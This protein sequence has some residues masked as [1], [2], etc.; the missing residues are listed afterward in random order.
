M[1][2]I[3]EFSF[4]KLLLIDGHSLAY[5][6]F[7]A[8]PPLSNAEGIPTQAL[9][10]VVNM[11][12]KILEDEKPTHMMVFFDKEIPAFRKEAYQ[13][14]KA[15]RKAPPDDFLT[16]LPFIEEFY[17]GVLEVPVVAQPGFEADDWIASVVHQAKSEAEQILI[18][19]ADL[20]L[21]QL[22]SENVVVLAS[23]RGTSQF[24]RYTPLEVEK[25]FGVKPFQIPDLKALVGDASDNILGIPGIGEKT[26]A[27]LLQQ[28]GSI[29][30]LFE[31][32]EELPNKFKEKL[33]QF[34][35]QLFLNKAL[36]TLKKDAPIPFQ[37][38]A[39]A[40]KPFHPDKL[41]HFF[42]RFE[43]KKL[44]S[45]LGV[46]AKTNIESP[47]FVYVEH[48]ETLTRLL[49]DFSQTPCAGLLL[50]PSPSPFWEE[51]L[52]AVYLPK[53]ETY[54][55]STD[56]AERALQT[57]FQKKDSKKIFAYN[58]KSF[59]LAGL[60]K[61]IV[62]PNWKVHDVFITGWLCNSNYT[63]SSL[64]DLARLY[65]GVVL[66]EN[67]PQK[68]E[69]A[70]AVLSAWVS[71]LCPLGE[72]LEEKVKSL[73]LISLYEEMEFPLI[74]VLARMEQ[75]GVSLDLAYLQQLSLELREELGRLE[76]EIYKEAG[77]IFNINSSK[78]LADVLYHKLQ[79]PKG[80]KTKTGYSTDVEE[81]ERLSNFSLVPTL[82][83]QYREISKLLNTYVEAFPKLIHP[84]TGR[85]HTTF[86]QTGT[87][88]GRLSSKE[89][90]LQNIP[91]RTEYGKK[92][93]KAFVPGKPG[94]KILSADYSQIELRLLAHFSEDP[95]LIEAFQNHE[96][97]H[98]RTA[99]EIFGVKAD[100]VTPL[101]R[102][103]AKSVNFGILY[104][105]TEHGLSQSLGIKKED[106]REFIK[107]Y[108][109]RFP[110]VQAYLEASLEQ[111]RQAGATRTL[112]GRLRFM[113]ELQSQKGYVR[114]QAERMGVNAP[115]QGSAADL[116]KLA[117]IRVQKRL[118][119]EN[120]QA[121]MIMQV[122]DELVFE[123]PPHEKKEVARLV[124]E[125]MEHTANFRV[126]LVV[127]LAV[128]E[129]WAE[130]VEVGVGS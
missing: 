99:C 46:N 102:R 118:D 85:L 76:G 33:K 22:V 109:E 114:Q 60:Q 88:T 61:N 95:V 47:P 66:P 65:M 73:S 8:L 80:R 69:E 77:L 82:L 17:A 106:A 36:I 124:K 115:L 81:L 4:M 34:K 112:W 19:S 59:V 123:V 87:V 75:N 30:N 125:E 48:D 62:L 116:I 3:A 6:A 68:H 98:T 38:D 37:A 119:E 10:G 64:P 21:L 23:Q 44:A 74:S 100:E 16:Q 89:P 103:V 28:W 104:G 20:D 15:T 1:C 29:E 83:L 27:E 93:R 91:I 120:R 107:N 70:R 11:T 79:L 92:M 117:M 129:S 57:L 101:M 56:L 52:L 51:H 12:F 2:R 122:H 105:M 63:N 67:V 130:Q 7:Y 128:G 53:K 113:P 39:C 58:W 55:V 97:I 50:W 111:A 9:L 54:V 41:R 127:D 72:H 31:H 18:L 13:A 126:P 78:Q 108:R 96:D 32:L 26:A 121:F 84:K 49:E 35:E 94:W 43:F 14:Y 25:K 110:K 86:V 90:N 42:E 5:R 40:V 24:T 45:R 71:Q